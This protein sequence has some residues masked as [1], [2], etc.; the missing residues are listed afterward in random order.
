MKH[1][2]NRRAGRAFARTA[3]S[4][5]SSGATSRST[6]RSAPVTPRPPSPPRGAWRSRAT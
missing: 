2:A 1:V 4:R 3:G 6:T 5:R